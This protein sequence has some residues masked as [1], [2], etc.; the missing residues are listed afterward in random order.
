M[1]MIEADRVV[2]IL[3]D[4]LFTNEELGA[5]N[6]N[7]VEGGAVPADA[8]FVDGIITRFGFN[9]QRLEQHREEISAMLLNLPDPFM[10]SKGGGWSF[11]QAC[12]DRSGEQWTGLHQTMDQLFTLGIAI[13]K[14][15]YL[16]P[17]EMWSS[18]PG[19]MPYLVVEDG[20][21]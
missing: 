1:P 11:L 17:R 3:K 2:A 19:Q 12:A 4:C 6:E 14:V 20:Q 16:L 10:R 8:V 13:G 9:A 7:G 21:I 18:L 5:F 15:A